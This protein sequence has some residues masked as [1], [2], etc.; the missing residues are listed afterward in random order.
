M[1]T[2]IVDVVVLK[3]VLEKSWGKDTSYKAIW[4]E[5]NKSLGQCAVTA[6]L[7]QYYL[8]GEIYKGNIKDERYS[9][10]WN[11]LPNGEVIDLTKSQ[12]GKND[13]QFVNVKNKKVNE[14]MCNND[15]KRRYEIL[16]NRVEHIFCVYDD[17]YNVNICGKDPLKV[18]RDISKTNLNAKVMIIAEA[19][20]LEQVRLSGVN[21]FYKDG[22]IGNTGRYLEK[23]LN[24][25]NCSVYPDNPNCVYHTE[26]VH[27]FPGYV[28][29]NNKKTIRRPNKEEI[30]KSIVRFRTI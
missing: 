1:N 17:I 12:F 13:I 2:N 4:S 22:R 6:L 18:R 7:V 19:M 26:I 25:V 24:L 9:H 3:K 30:Q 21:Y 15:V 29:K 10:F 5:E 23:F 16:K 8:Q 27:S 28:L 11:V 20:A 14:L